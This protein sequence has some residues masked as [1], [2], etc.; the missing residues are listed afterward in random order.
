M[1]V[2]LSWHQSPFQTPF[3]IESVQEVLLFG[4]FQI[5]PGRQCK[6]DLV[7]GLSRKWASSGPAALDGKQPQLKDIFLRNPNVRTLCK[8]PALS[9]M[10]D[11]PR[12]S[13]TRGIASLEEHTR[14]PRGAPGTISMEKGLESLP[15]CR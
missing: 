8:G 1:G 9:E 4:N 12:I 2:V 13:P 11:C 5:R 6:S 15:L 14:C 3:V 7:L 10:E